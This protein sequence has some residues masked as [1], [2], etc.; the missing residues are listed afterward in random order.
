MGEIT[1]EVSASLRP[2]RVAVIFEWIT[3]EIWGVRTGPTE[4]C[5]KHLMDVGRG[6]P[7]LSF[8]GEKQ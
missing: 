6:F 2:S 7:R 8:P 1:E 5:G 3:T 4:D